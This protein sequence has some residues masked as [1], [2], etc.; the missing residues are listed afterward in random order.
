[1]YL[2][3][4]IFLW[5]TRTDGKQ[6][7]YLTARQRFLFQRDAATINMVTK[8]ELITRL[9]RPNVTCILKVPFP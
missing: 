7:N 9:S 6:R 1:M 3:V 4:F 5:Q 2:V 8:R